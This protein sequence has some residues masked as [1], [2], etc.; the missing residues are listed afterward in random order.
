MED[1]TP[2]ASENLSFEARLC[3]AC[4]MCCNG[5]LFHG[6]SL[7][8]TDSIRALSAL[9]LRLKRRDGQ[10]QFQQPCPA[11]KDTCCGIYDK[12]PQRCRDFSCRQLQEWSA[13]QLTEESAF[14]KIQEAKILTDRV[15]GLFQ[16]LGDFRENKPFATRYAGIFTPPLNPSPES[17]KFRS[18]LTVVMKSLEEL[19]AADFHGEVQ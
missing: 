5:V 19:L 13:G 11:W 4:G 17:E 7:E 9:G 3:A 8:P 2:P 6:T 12:R 16:K 18:E 10:M 14:E 15:R 1:A